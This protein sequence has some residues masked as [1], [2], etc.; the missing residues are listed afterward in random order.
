MITTDIINRILPKLEIESDLNTLTKNSNDTRDFYE[1]NYNLTNIFFE[2]IN[3]IQ[4]EP[5]FMKPI[6]VILFKII[7]S[8]LKIPICFLKTVLKIIHTKETN[9]IE[10][11]E[12][13]SIQVMDLSQNV[14]LGTINQIAHAIFVEPKIEFSA[15]IK[16]EIDLNNDHLK[17]I[18]EDPNFINY[19]D[20]INAIYHN[21]SNIFKPIP[22]MLLLD[23]THPRKKIYKHARSLPLNLSQKKKYSKL[24]TGK[25][26]KKMPF[27]HFFS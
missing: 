10:S 12:K 8:K 9:Q 2:N 26:A 13:S 19:I 18:T 24:R 4:V 22:A 5:L 15:L 14:E 6:L 20:E 7:I 17:Q 23:A 3:P 16:D 21:F 27:I 1:D 11:D 25:S